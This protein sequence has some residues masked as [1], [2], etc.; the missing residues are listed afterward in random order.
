LVTSSQ[1]VSLSNQERTRRIKQ[2]L[3]RTKLRCYDL[4]DDIDGNDVKPIKSEYP[5][6]DN[7]YPM[8]LQEAKSY[9]HRMMQENEKV[10]KKLLLPI[11]A[12]KRH[13]SEAKK[14]AVEM[15]KKQV[16]TIESKKLKNKSVRNLIEYL[17]A[18]QQ[19][20]LTHIPQ[21]LI[22]MPVKIFYD[23]F[24]T[25]DKTESPRGAVLIT[26]LTRTIEAKKPEGKLLRTDAAPRAPDYCKSDPFPIQR[27]KEMLDQLRG[28]KMRNDS[29]QKNIQKAIDVIET[30]MIDLLSSPVSVGSSEAFN[31]MEEEIT[32]VLKM[33]SESEAKEKNQKVE[34]EKD[35]NKPATPTLKRGLT[36]VKKA[37]FVEVKPGA[38]DQSTDGQKTKEEVKK[39][40]PKKIC[41]EESDNKVSRKVSREES[42]KASKE[43]GE[44]KKTGKDDGERVV[45]R[46][47]IEEKAKKVPKEEKKKEESEKVTIK[48][49]ECP[50]SDRSRHGRS[51]KFHYEEVKKAANIEEGERLLGQV[52]SVIRKI[53]SIYTKFYDES[54]SKSAASKQDSNYSNVIEF[55]DGI[56]QMVEPPPIRILYKDHEDVSLL[57]QAASSYCQARVYHPALVESHPP[58]EEEKA[59]EFVD[60]KEE[61]EFVEAKEEKK[62]VVEAK[63]E[64]VEEA[65]KDV[66]EDAKKE[67][68]EEAKKEVVEEAKK[69]VVETKKEVV[70]VK[71]EVVD[72]K[73]EVVEA[74]KEVVEAKEEVVEVKKELVELKQTSVDERKG[75]VEAK[76]EVVEP[77]KVSVE[78]GICR[79]KNEP[80]KMKEEVVEETS[81]ELTEREDVKVTARAQ[82]VVSIVEKRRI[83]DRRHEF[84]LRAFY[85]LFFSSIFIALNFDYTS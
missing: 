39:D 11:E 72:V 19:K 18:P 79:V 9:L 12:K 45:K 37:A 42:R 26:D 21:S 51:S 41:R 48:V 75:L 80:K 84:T 62:E 66:V 23:N 76:K 85:T 68:V 52:D 83:E 31:A 35:D 4:L 53:D 54:K 59:D 60:A 43:E 24:P 81:E 15:K 63:M 61:R 2:G 67:V 57:F 40:D 50:L 22:V 17:T 28:L 25:K 78:G 8:K 71:M 16:Q 33:M 1:P 20:F 55:I 14:H 58:K 32:N 27:K 3:G 34:A 5:R 69:E 29:I 64:A 36:T 82:D 65:K 38:G 47:V 30:K 49:K 70:E 73:K 56:K 44:R 7:I 10:W 77:E 13:S 74:K 46:V 6:R